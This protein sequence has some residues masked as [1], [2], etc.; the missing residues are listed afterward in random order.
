MT[1]SISKLLNAKIKR[2]SDKNRNPKNKANKDE[3][4]YI[5]FAKKEIEKGRNPLPKTNINNKKNTVYY[6]II[7]NQM[8]LQC[9]GKVNTE[10]KPSTMAKINKMY[11]Y[12]LATVYNINEIRG[13]WVVE[14]NKKI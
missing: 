3:L 6:P 11:P 8:C 14:M 9:H 1:D 12:D 2:V 10:I 13:I 5:D 7:S 4:A